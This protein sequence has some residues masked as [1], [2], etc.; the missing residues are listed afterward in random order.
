MN[1]PR[2]CN[3]FIL[4]CGLSDNIC[5]QSSFTNRN[6]QRLWRFSI[7]ALFSKR[8]KSLPHYV[9]LILQT[10]SDFYVHFASHSLHLCVPQSSFLSPIFDTCSLC[11][12]LWTIIIIIQDSPSTFSYS[13]QMKLQEAN[14]PLHDNKISKMEQRSPNKT[15]TIGKLRRNRSLKG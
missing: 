12:N 6:Q 5:A 9:N 7:V 15:L 8:V 2:A 11:S 4:K 10:C 14:N 13:L 1:R 3:Y